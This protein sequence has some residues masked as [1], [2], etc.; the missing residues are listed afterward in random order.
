MRWRSAWQ[1]PRCLS[2]ARSGAP[3]RA[4]SALTLLLALSLSACGSLGAAQATPQPSATPTPAAVAVN[5]GGFADS[6]PIPADAA[7]CAATS[8]FRSAAAA[9]SGGL[10]FA[11]IPYPAQSVAYQAGSAA[12]LY[13]FLK[14]RLCVSG[15]TP[16]SV[17][18][19]FLS[20][21]PPNGWKPTKTY[22]YNED[23]ASGCGDPYCWRKAAA[24]DVRYVSIE[25]MS[26]ATGAV[27]FTLRFASA[28]Q[29]SASLAIRSDARTTYAAFGTLSVSAS[30]R[31][32]EQM[33]SGGY[34]I[35]SADHGYSPY[36]NYPS[37]PNTWTVVVKAAGPSS[38]TLQT[39]VGCLKANYPL[40]TKIV[41]A[42]VDVAKG[43][44]QTDTATCPAGSVVTGGGFTLSA[45]VGVAST[46]APVS[47]LG[48][49]T[50][51][52]TGSGDALQATSY[53][54]CATRN[55][56]VAPDVTLQFN[57]F[58]QN[59]SGQQS[60]SCQGA[61]QLLLGGGYS[62]NDDSA[63]GKIAFE[64]NAATAD[65]SRWFVQG[66]NVDPASPHR[67]TL[68]GV[69]VLPAPYF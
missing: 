14:M 19:A 37:G 33:V 61:D 65:Y 26:A 11:D 67:V 36:A 55:L 15:A 51:V 54:L 45:P 20:D 57:I 17:L 21:L 6:P 5:K 27:A 30:C 38:F 12:N 68:W 47:G 69:C 52:A 49:W 18:R 3:L 44:S 1:W 4:V 66:R 29:P 62:N 13:G 9:T 24:G 50:M 48:G 34:Y 25:S 63:N 32:G 35:I 22:P 53:A 31:A 58:N 60:I 23:A 46:T 8:E 39:Y 41:T 16:D 28:P 10:G 56:A 7:N 2:T 59:D 43:A 64:L 42:N 40:A